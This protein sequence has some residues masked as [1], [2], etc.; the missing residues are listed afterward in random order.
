[1]TRRLIACAAALAASALAVPAGAS[2]IVDHVAATGPGGLGLDGL[3]ARAEFAIDGTRLSILLQNTSTATPF[4]ADSTD[5]LL[6][7][8]AFDLTDGVHIVDGLGAVIGA[9]SRGLGAWSALGAGADV[10]DQWLWTNDGGGDYL[11]GFDQV[12]STSNGQGGGD[13]MSFNGESGPN[14]SG[15]W[16]GI[17]ADPV[18]GNVPGSQEAVS[19]SILFTL[20]LSDM[21]TETQLRDVALGSVVEFGSDYRYGMVPAPASAALLLLAAGVGRRR[22]R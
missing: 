13:T 16:G 1:M 9:E 11:E 2:F 19:S 4:G 8:L 20:E 12:I 22:R 15:P 7:S 21:L 5:S 14:V 10:G 3:A 18:L 6:V 17:A